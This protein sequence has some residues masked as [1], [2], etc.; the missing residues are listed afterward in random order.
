MRFYSVLRSYINI[1]TSTTMGK[2]NL[3][4]RSRYNRG[5]V[6][7]NENIYRVAPHRLRHWNVLALDAAF[8]NINFSDANKFEKNRVV[9]RNRFVARPIK[10]PADNDNFL[11]T[12]PTFA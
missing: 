9:E 2:W 5:G 1:E 3:S 11:G 8:I 10:R 12:P 7:V 6:F 4:K